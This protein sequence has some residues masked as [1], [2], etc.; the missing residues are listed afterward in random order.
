MIRS[1]LASATSLSTDE[2]P[3][4]S[5]VLLFNSTERVFIGDVKCYIALDFGIEQKFRAPSFGKEKIYDYVSLCASR[6]DG[7][8]E[9]LWRRYVA[10]CPDHREIR[11]DS[12]HPRSDLA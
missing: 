1:N 7:H 10:H 4:L 5:S 3:R 2:D 6:H 8:C 12:N 11:M 9:E